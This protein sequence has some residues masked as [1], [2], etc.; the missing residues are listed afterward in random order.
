MNVV[1]FRIIAIK[2]KIIYFYSK[3]YNYIST[4]SLNKRINKMFD[5]KD[6]LTI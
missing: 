2:K 3:I 1:K 6:I 4:Y 5:I